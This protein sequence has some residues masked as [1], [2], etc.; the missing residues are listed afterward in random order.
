MVLLVDSAAYIDLMREG[1]DPRQV[2]MPYMV[3]GELYNCGIV[4]AEVL[5]GMRQPRE[6]ADMEAFFDIVPEVPTDPK[7]WRK[8]SELGWKLGR[9]GKWPPVTDLAIAAC[10][11]RVGATVVSPDKHFEDIEGLSILKS[12]P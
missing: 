9:K 2:L 6:L 10:A 11:L 1:H 7:L 8:V 5:R 4:R 3:A 12:L